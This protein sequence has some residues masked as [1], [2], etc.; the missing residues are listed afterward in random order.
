MWELASSGGKVI[1]QLPLRQALEMSLLE[2]MLDLICL[3]IGALKMKLG[4][5]KS[6]ARSVALVTAA[7]VLC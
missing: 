5:V 1:C 7:E 6:K 2:L 4:S 3:P